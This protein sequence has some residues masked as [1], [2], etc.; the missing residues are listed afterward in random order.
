MPRVVAL[1]AL[2]ALLQPVHDAR[3]VSPHDAARPA[4]A[5]APEPLQ[6]PS[7]NATS[8][9]YKSARRDRRLLLHDD[10]RWTADPA[11]DDRFTR[12]LRRTVIL[13]AHEHS[14]LNAS[15]TLSDHLK[16]LDSSYGYM[17][18]ENYVT[19]KYGRF[20]R[21]PHSLISPFDMSRM[22]KK[23]KLKSKQDGASAPS[24]S[25]L[26]SSDKLFGYEPTSVVA[27]SLTPI[28]L[29]FSRYPETE[30]KT[31]PSTVT[32]VMAAT[33]EPI[34]STSGT[35]LSEV[36]PTNIIQVTS[37]PKLATNA[38]KSGRP[39]SKNK[40]KTLRK[41]KSTSSVPLGSKREARLA[42]KKKSE[43]ET[44]WPVKHA[45]VVEG[46]IILG[47]LM[48]VSLDFVSITPFNLFR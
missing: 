18:F 19:K 40:G 27:A 9:T 44:V 32:P 30:T 39:R 16:L 13:D 34:T 25:P 6:F 10:V 37:R 5:K 3:R 28:E 36:K 43:N 2:L 7:L 29:T 12:I 31:N 33:K 26:Q 14:L 11:Q 47:G 20:K 21:A 42:V 45:A 46:D 8:L 41:P 17:L 38:T 4:P 1:T 24:A 23:K 48:M 35:T 15:L 22:F